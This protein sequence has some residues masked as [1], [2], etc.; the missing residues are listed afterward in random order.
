MESIRFV[1]MNILPMERILLMKV[2]QVQIVVAVVTMTLLVEAPSAVESTVP[3]DLTRK[4]QKQL[5]CTII[6]I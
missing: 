4:Q 3:A 2:I 1:S 5:S 6:I